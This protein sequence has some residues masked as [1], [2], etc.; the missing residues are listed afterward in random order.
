VPL[1]RR[2]GKRLTETPKW[3]P[4]TVR[5]ILT[6]PAYIGLPTHRGKIVEGLEPQWDPLVKPDGFWTMQQVLSD[7]ARKTTRPSKG[8]HLCSYTIKCARCGEPMR[9]T[10]YRRKVRAARPTY[11]CTGRGCSTAIRQGDLDQYVERVLTGWLT[12][13]TVFDR[14]TAGDQSPDVAQARAEFARVSVELEELRQGGESG[15]VS[16]STLM[17]VEPAL[18]ARLGR[19]E[20]A[21]RQATMPPVLI[22]VI[23]PGAPA[24]WRALEMPQKRALLAAVADVRVRPIGRGNAPLVPVRDRVEWR[25]LIGEQA[26]AGGPPDV[27]DLPTIDGAYLRAASDR[28]LVRRRIRQSSAI[29]AAYEAGRYAYPDR[30]APGERQCVTPGCSN[31]LPAHS[32]PGQPRKR[33]ETC[34]PSTWRRLGRAS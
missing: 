2:K 1:S 29:A 9:Q 5:Q 21:L 22:D 27:A 33:C 28:L 31:V 20:Q 12:E 13:P 11:V 23:G 18:L 34:R 7:P 19:A 14:L 15:A 26:T 10:V 3:W 6:N 4:T 17:R 25:W 8:E 24:R 30:P 32:G 16:V